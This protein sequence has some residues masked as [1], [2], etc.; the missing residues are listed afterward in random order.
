MRRKGQPA[1]LQRLADILAP[2]LKKRG[3]PLNLE[4]QRIARAWDDA[5]GPRIAAE[6]RPDTLK[7]GILFVKVSNSVWMQQLHFLKAEIIEKVNRLLGKEAIGNLYFTIGDV[8]SQRPSRRD[9][10]PPFRAHPLRERERKMVEDWVSSVVD[11]ELRDIL[12][13]VMTGG[14]IRRKSR[15]GPQESA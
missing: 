12:K 9:S 3:I 11:D 15:K 14:I 8:S 1:K 13:R 10:P 4:T 2:A 5:V 7:R 6:T